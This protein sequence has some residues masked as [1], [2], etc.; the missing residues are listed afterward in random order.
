I[1]IETYSEIDLVRSGV[2][3]YTASSSFEILLFAY[4]FDD[5]EVKI[6]D[7]ARGEKIPNE[8]LEAIEDESIIK[9]AFNA[10]FE[11][12]CL[13][14]YLN[15]N[16]SARSWRCT[17]IHGLT[18][19]LPGS[20]EALAEK[21]G[22]EKQKM[23]EGKALIKYF[24]IP[25]KGKDNNEQSSF[26]YN[27]GKVNRNYPDDSL[28]KWEL[29]KKYCIQDVEVERA[30]RKK[31]ERFPVIDKEHELY[32][33]DQEINDRGIS[34]D[35]NLVN[36]AIKCDSYHKDKLL[37]EIKNITNLTNPNSVTQLKEWLSEKGV[38]VKSLSQDIIKKLVEKCDGDFKKVLELRL[39]L[40]K[41]SVK[42]YEAIKRALTND[43]RVRGLFQ[44]YGASRTGR[45][46]G[47]LVQVHNLPQNHLENIDLYRN[48]IKNGDLIEIEKKVDNVKQVL[49]ELIRSAFI[50]T[51]GHRFIIVDFSAI[52]AR[53]LAYIAR[54]KWRI[55]VFK[56]HG[57]IYEASASKMFKVPIDDITRESDLRQ[58]GKISELALGY[59]GSVGALK[60]MGAIEMGI[61]EDELKEL[62]NT[63]RASNINIVKL[64]WDIHKAAIN[65]LKNREINTVS[66]IKI[67][68]EGD[69][70]FI[71][72]PSGRRLAYVK[73]R[74]EKNKY[75]G[76]SITYEGVSNS[77]KWERIETYGPKLV[78]N[79]VQAIARD[80]LAEAMLRLRDKGYKIVMH[81]HDEIVIE[82]KESEGSLEEVIDIMI[83]SPSWAKD[84]TLRAEGFESKYYRK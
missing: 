66:N 54:E 52:E 50:P 11:R 42:K 35:I 56:S 82:A 43:F 15:K 1:D 60:A 19:G 17:A 73:P 53:I 64:W 18:L 61:P 67:Y 4:A 36:N 62:V 48:L 83:E 21:L 20:L 81:V 59:G 8:I 46:A 44:F 24:S 40:S 5:E 69:I 80:I 47:R 2:Y 14:K 23:K 28:E 49:S 3:S 38:E 9:T 58:K 13:S 10:N 16:L 27:I 39:K 6:I 34:I 12:V 84:L 51:S 65:A 71:I 37:N 70:M 29:F 30:I 78:E 63:W 55:D 22:L 31:L 76:D 68:Y 72:L 79:I 77:K 41:T 32:V 33:L 75:G 57:K 26:E 45:W 74:I 7:I 25:C